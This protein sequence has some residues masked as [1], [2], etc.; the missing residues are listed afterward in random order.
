MTS[1]LVLG[2]TSWLGGEIAKASLA[3]GYDVTC[4]ARGEAGEPPPGVAFVASDRDGDDPYAEVQDTRWDQ[5]FDVSWQPRFVREAVQ[6]LGP[7]TE[8]WIYVSSVSIYADES[9]CGEDE[10]AELLPP[11]QA[12]H[13]DWET[14]GEAKARCEE[15]VQALPRTL[16]ARAGLL[17]GPGDRSDRFGYWVSRFAL[18]GDGPVL[19]PDAPQQP[20]QIL[21]ARDLAAWLVK[22][23]DEGTTGIFNAVGEKSTLGELIEASAQVAGHM[24]EVV[25]ADPDWLVEQGVQPWSGPKSLP[26][27]VPGEDGLGSRSSRAVGLNR[28]PLSRLVD[29]TLAYEMRLGLDRG[30]KAGLTR[31]EELD[32]IARIG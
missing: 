1:V 2:G 7:V 21:D 17:G 23:A 22:A 31:T 3:R 5:V 9:T 4:L 18:A 13:A 10:D 6:A 29:D 30:R 20:T 24:G 28:R 11:L 26:L 19:V 32:L 14:Y 8:I 25:R 27:W 15:I 12:G 16:I